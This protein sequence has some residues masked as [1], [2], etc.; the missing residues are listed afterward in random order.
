MLYK[1][2][3]I[4]N[5]SMN[6]KMFMTIILFFIVPLI[7]VLFVFN[8]YMISYSEREISKSVITNLKTIKNMNDILVESI[9][10]DIIRFSLNTELSSLNGIRSYND[11][12]GNADNLIKLNRIS[13]SIRTIN[14]SNFRL[15]SIYIYQE[16]A[17]YIITSNEEGIVLKN[18]FNDKG[19]IDIYNKKKDEANGTIWLKG[20][21]VGGGKLDN[22]STSE[23]VITFL[24][25][26]KNV[27]LD[28]D[29]VIVVNVKEKELT[30][31]IND[32]ELN[33]SGTVF[34][35]GKDGEPITKIDESITSNNTDGSDF[36]SKVI[37]SPEDS[38]YII[39]KINNKKQ[40][41]AYNKTKF[42]DWIYVGVFPLNT[43]MKNINELKT[44]I[45][46]IIFLIVI[47]GVVMSYIISKKLYHPLNT[48][49]N[50]VKQLK[51]IDL[52]DGENEMALL[53]RAF[54]TIEKQGDDLQDIIEKNK[55]S[56]KEKY[57]LNLLSG[58]TESYNDEANNINEGNNIEESS[59]K[60][61]VCTILSIDKLENFVPVYT[62]QQQYYMKV[63]TMKVCEEVLST[64]YKCDSIL[65]D[66]NKMVIILNFNEEDNNKVM[67]DLNKR[68]NT[69]QE[70]IAK[71]FDNSVTIAIGGCHASKIG[72]KD[73]FVEAL[74]AM[75]HKLIYGYG[76]IINWNDDLARE[77]EYYYPINIEKHIMN[78]LSLGL[79]EETLGAVKEL[80]GE[81]RNKPNILSDNIM[82]IFIQLVGNTI[83]QLMD[84]NIKISDIFGHDCSIYQKISSKET[85]D[86]IEIC[87]TGFY[88]EILGYM[89]INDTNGNDH[90]NKVF[91]FIQANLKNNIDVTAIADYSG[92]SYS[93]VRKIV[94]DKSGKS[95]VDYINNLRIEQSKKLLK[96]T[97]MSMA[98]IALEIGYNN[99]QSFNRFF[100]KYEGIT[101]GE[102]RHVG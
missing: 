44:K 58:D 29:G 21:D 19:W 68:F 59:L 16:Y 38:G 71:V 18:G 47:F 60:Y 12:K 34:I 63:L 28:L 8:F 91:E 48:L 30:N 45:S 61:F 37:G 62:K 3:K 6:I 17:D 36:V 76:K 11:L 55:A 83:K 95:V 101:P 74:E 35:M 72:I 90:S 27:S 43:L 20:R 52:Q 69:V 86:E 46:I 67:E 92:I 4:K 40:I 2:L 56:S 10:R 53:S 82:Q 1:R 9:S 80:I 24:L 85:L 66:K 87:L 41:I 70:E 65:Y 78:N 7:T 77:N 97:N 79:K 54:S 84:N 51:G 32:T 15:H 89:K 102:Y 98:K 81:I 13:N 26:L 23:G 73:S 50:A 94:K 5:S 64:S 49:V 75:K 33:N 96:E 57:L 39:Q 31:L 14:N 42:N 22:S 100:Q 93:Y 99:Y 88:K 25:P